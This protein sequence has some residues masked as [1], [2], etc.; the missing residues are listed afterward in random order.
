[1]TG[2]PLGQSLW[3]IELLAPEYA[4]LLLCGGLAS[5]ARIPHN[6]SNRPGQIFPDMFFSTHNGRL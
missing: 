1:M 6:Q 3:H 4:C 5:P 2:L